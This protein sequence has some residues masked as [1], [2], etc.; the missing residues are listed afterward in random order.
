[1]NHKLVMALSCFSLFIAGCGGDSGNDTT[2]EDEAITTLTGVFIDS[3]VANISY[4]TETQSGTTNIHGE[5]TYLAGENLTFSIGE[6]E[7][8]TVKAMGVITPMTLAGHSSIYNQ[9]ATNIAMLLQSLDENGILEGGITIPVDAASAASASIDFTAT[10]ADFINN[11]A[12]TNMVANAGINRA[13][14]VSATSAQQH[15]QDSINELM[16]Y[17]GA[18]SLVSETQESHLVLFADNTF[19]YAEND[20]ELPNGLEYGHYSYDNRNGDLTFSISYDNN[21]PGEDSGVGD[22]GTDVTTDTALSNNNNTL[23]ILNGAMTFSAQNLDSSSI[24][25]AWS[26]VDS[27][28]KLQI[29]LFDDNTFLIAESANKDPNGLQ[30]GRYSYD[31]SAAEITLSLTYDDTRDG[32]GIGSSDEDIIMDAVLSDDKNTLSLMN[33]GVILNRAL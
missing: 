14:L 7:L 30:L 8:P 29:I 15:L 18:W 6:L 22:I 28:Q 33:G 17:V 31:A 5:F 23:K 32:S 3:K 1:M 24:V 20:A 13:S 12:V 25:G 9:T 21:G 19:I 16:P 2:N 4:Q 26:P 10:T 11:A 27:N